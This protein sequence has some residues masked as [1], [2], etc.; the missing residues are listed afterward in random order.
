MDAINEQARDIDT[1]ANDLAA[2]V[3]QCTSEISL[4]REQSSH[5]RGRVSAYVALVDAFEAEHKLI[6][7]SQELADR[8]IGHMSD[9]DHA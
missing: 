9:E 7:P 6:Q 3:V 8:D 2:L 1:V 5:L 4:L